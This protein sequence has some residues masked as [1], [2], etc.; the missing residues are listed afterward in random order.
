MILAIRPV[1]PSFASHSTHGMMSKQQA[2]HLLKTGN[3]ASVRA[4]PAGDREIILAKLALDANHTDETIQILSS[5]ILEQNSLAALVRA[6]AYRR[7]SVAAAKRAGHYAH[8]VTGDISTLQQ[9]RL[10]GALTMAEARLQSFMADYASRRTA[11]LAAKKSHQLLVKQSKSTPPAKPTKHPKP[12]KPHKQ[13]VP[14][15]KPSVASTKPTKAQP[16]T[17]AASSPPAKISPLESVRQAL[18]AWRK[19]WESRN[20]DAYLS[21]YHSHFRT[22]KYNRSTWATHKRRINASKTY[23]KVAL[24]DIAI[25]RGPEKITE[26]EAVL[27]TFYQRYQSSNYATNSRKQLYLVRQHEHDPWLILYEGNAN[28]PYHRHPTSVANPIVSR[29]KPHAQGT[30]QAGTWTINLGSFDSASNARQMMAAIKLSGKQQPFVSS[31]SIHGKT[32]HRV[33]LGFY[34]SRSD[35]VDAML[36]VCPELGLTHCWLEQVK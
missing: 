14:S 1:S 7:Q 2:Y 12:S 24:S 18:Q 36:K 32:M 21:H 20:N 3:D 29:P 34:A 33:S 5:K 28:P 8:A 9:A 23:I 19:D 30:N 31:P 16:V 35:A 26:G 6:E 25:I 22:S 4:L 10:D 15:H 13:T 27:V 11:A 17:V